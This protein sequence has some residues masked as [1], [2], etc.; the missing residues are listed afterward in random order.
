[1]HESER[2]RLLKLQQALLLALTDMDHA[3]AALDALER[4]HKNVNLM[5][6]LETA[7]AV[8][9]GR[10]FTTSSLLRLNRDEYR[11]DDPAQAQLHDE[12]LTLRDKV[13]AHTDKEGGRTAR[14]D[15]TAEIE[16]GVEGSE[17]NITAEVHEQWVPLRREGIPDYR[18]LIDGQRRRFGREAVD[19]DSRFDWEAARMVPTPVPTSELEKPD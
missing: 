1:M 6:A 13:Y 16:Q 18:L 12:L 11:P 10:A 3:R 2:N 8:S 4:E 19:I 17:I 9:Y 14:I 15:V 5:R 7:I